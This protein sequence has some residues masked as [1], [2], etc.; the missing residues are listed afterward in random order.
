MNAEV[1]TIL[2]L[3]GLTDKQANSITKYIIRQQE[4]SRFE[5]CQVQKNVVSEL[6]G[7]LVGVP[8]LRVYGVP[9]P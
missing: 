5:Y 2:V 9:S 7:R 8:T 1:D 4:N 3:T 6:D